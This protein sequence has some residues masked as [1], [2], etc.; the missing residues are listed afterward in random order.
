M[1]LKKAILLLTFLPLYLMGQINVPVD[2]NSGRPSLS[3]PIYTVKNG[4]LSLP[5]SVYYSGGGIRVDQGDGDYE[6][7]IGWDLNAGGQVSRIVKSLPDDLLGSGSDQRVGW[8]HGSGPSQV[9]GFNVLNSTG[10]GGNNDNFNFINSISLTQDTEPDVFSFSAPG[11]SG[12]FVFDNNKVIR[13]IPYQDIDISP[14]YSSTGSIIHVLITAK[15]G[16]K[17]F[18]RPTVTVNSMATSDPNN[19]YLRNNQDRYPL[20]TLY[21]SEWGLAQITSPAGASIYLSYGRNYSDVLTTTSSSPA[22]F[23]FRKSAGDYQK[24][25]F[26]QILTTR[27]KSLLSS[28]YSGGQNIEINNNGVGGKSTTAVEYGNSERF[29]IYANGTKTKSVVFKTDTYGRRRYLKSIYEINDCLKNPPYEFDY[30]GLTK[31]E[32]VMPL[33]NS[34][35][36]DFW[37]YYNNNKATTLLPD[38]HI[39]PNEQGADRY[40]LYKIDGYSNTYIPLSGG[41]DRRANP[42]TAAA[43][44]LYRITFPAGGNVKLEYESNEFV[45]SKTGTFLKGAGIRVNKVITHDGV[46]YANDIVK[47]YSYAP[48]KLLNLPQFVL[49]LH[50]YTNFSG[51]T[52]TIEQMNTYSLADKYDYLTARSAR[53]LNSYSSEHPNVIY[54]TVEEIQAGKGKTIYS[55]TAPATFGQISSTEYTSP[56]NWEAT[57]TKIATY[58]DANNNCISI[59]TLANGYFSYPYPSNTNYD[60]ERGLIKSIKS[61]NEAG[62]LVKENQFDYTPVYQNTNPV[63]VYGLAYETFKNASNQKVF[64]FGKY[65][66]L[67]GISKLVG[68]SKEIT[69]DPTNFSRL[70]IVENRSFYNSPNHRFLSSTETLVSNDGTNSTK[71]TTTFKYPKDF[72]LPTTLNDQAAIGLKKLKERLINDMVIE[73]ASYITKPNETMKLIGADLVKFGTFSGDR[74][75]PSEVLKLSTNTPLNNFTEASASSGVFIYDARYQ[76]NNYF[77]DYNSVGNIKGAKNRQQ[78][79]G[80]HYDKAEVVVVAD[81][82]NATAKQ[83]VYSNFDDEPIGPYGATATS[84]DKMLDQGVCLPAEGRHGVALSVPP[85]VIFYKNNIEKGIGNNAVVSFWLKTTVAGTSTVTL[86]DAN[87]QTSVNT[88]NYPATA[89]LWKYISIEI[90]VN[91]LAAVF[92]VQVKCNTPVYIDDLVFRPELA[93]ITFY[94]YKNFNNTMIADILGNT[95]FNE[96]DALGRLVLYRDKNKNIKKRITYNYRESV[97]LNATINISSHDDLNQLKINQ[98]VA[99]KTGVDVGC[100]VSGLTRNWNFGDGT[101]LNDGGVNPSHTY[102]TPGAYTVS[103]TVIHPDYGTATSQIQIV[104]R[105]SIAMNL[106]TGGITAYNV[107]DKKVMTTGSCGSYP[108]GTNTFT[109]TITTPCASYPNYYYKWERGWGFEPKTWET[110]PGTSNIITVQVPLNSDGTVGSSQAYTIRCTVTPSCLASPVTQTSFINFFKTYCNN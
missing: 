21:T 99:F 104:V 50:L 80:S 70:A 56:Y 74:V 61:F 55:Y 10:C 66:L 11:L 22:D 7:G 60:F 20:T 25:L 86:T 3:I 49:P 27:T 101:T 13:T 28:V 96:Y 78:N 109:A 54:E 8:I 75:L 90:P 102:S 64:A 4:D 32:A 59:G 65:K 37:G 40:R 17:Y 83:V 2:L 106:C 105:A 44:S 39:Y 81:I 52:L 85:N 48:G 100:E 43:S 108:L 5:I 63:L 30:I 23:Y 24:R 84:F 69:Y 29:I 72:S 47:E 73:K 41:A 71:Y 26:Y 6:Y 76:S 14:T 58:R 103:L 67:T 34:E 51:G 45:D 31:Y 36:Q 92:S 89:G 46:S 95:E 82:K 68:T 94:G 19:G 9:N 77:L 16:V 97:A 12:Q 1:N 35:E 62:Q 88:I 91:N 57:Y 110:L 42:A 107:C 98:P 38:I 93:S 18:F 33:S 79:V 87:N 53:D 15:N